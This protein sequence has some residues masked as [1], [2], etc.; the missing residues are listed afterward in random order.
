M[1]HW[2]QAFL[3]YRVATL[4][5]EEVVQGTLHP[6]VDP[7]SE[8]ARA[9]F[10]AWPGA[11]YVRRTPAGTEV[12]LVRRLAGRRPERWWLHGVLLLATL[13]TTT[14]AGVLLRGDDA[15][16][17]AWIA[18]GPL[19]LPI[20][21]GV[22]WELLRHGLV[23]SL[24]LLAIL[25]SH[26]MGHYLAGRRHRMDISPPYFVPVPHWLN[27][28]GTF[29]A[30]IRLRSAL[31]NRLVLLDVGAAGPLAGFALALPAAALGLALSTPAAAPGGGAPTPFVV[32]FG[33]TPVWLGGS[34]LF[35][36]LAS[37]WA[38]AGGV[39]ILHPLAFAAWLGLLVTSLNLFPLSQLDGGHILFALGGRVQSAV[40]WGFL[41][42][43]LVLGTRWTGWWVWAA[44]ILLIG[45]GRVHHPP[46]WDPSPLTPGRRAAAWACV[47][48]F[49]LTF[50]PVPLQV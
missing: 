15:V 22:R 17:V 37:V 6:G 23:F 26:E 13:F 31:L 21:A 3:T 34:L 7:E 42:L 12:T 40:A 43:L 24:P 4:G 11:R 10:G 38:P 35:R 45:R 46:T 47:A 44:M 29:G 41:A 8:T 27:L 18:L 49:V 30:F 5:D 25:L 50:V 20:P 2:T 19:A 16:R 14:A 1:T 36:A 32:I 39:L 28:I 33:G 48:L 9:V